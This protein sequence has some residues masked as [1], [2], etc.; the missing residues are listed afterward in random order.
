[1]LDLL[2]TRY[3]DAE[4]REFALQ[5]SQKEVTELMNSLE[6]YVTTEMERVFEE[7]NLLPHLETP[8]QSYTDGQPSPSVERPISYMHGEVD[9]A[10]AAE[11]G[12]RL[13]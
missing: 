4:L 7:A 10:M 13:P 2:R 1:M 11:A 8:P 9:I 6:N 12:V 3:E 5:E